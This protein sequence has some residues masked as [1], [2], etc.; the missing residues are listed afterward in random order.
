MKV[1]L[2]D[3]FGNLTV[4]SEIVIV[5]ESRPRVKV[6]VRC[7]C[8]S[9]RMIRT[10]HLTGTKTSNCK[11]CGMKKAWQTQESFKSHK[12]IT[13]GQTN[14]PTHISWM[15]MK[16]RCY[17]KDSNGYKN[18]GGR[19]ITVCERWMSFENF[20]A[21]MGN[22]PE[23]MTLDR[24]DPDKNYMPENCRWQTTRQQGYNKRITKRFEYKG[25]KRS[26]FELHEM[27]GTPIK[28]LEGRLRRG[29]SVEKA[30]NTPLD[31]KKSAISRRRAA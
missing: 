12:N 28:L 18:Y 25:K 17:F 10:E 2:G 8:G 3:V 7:V 4:I 27:S 14:S 13:H 15:S 22:R 1:Q 11:S 20:L 21:D 23:G 19:G 30:I 5:Q 26:L 24:I 9:E 16:R 29:W 31:K 6:R